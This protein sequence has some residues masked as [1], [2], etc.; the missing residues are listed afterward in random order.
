MILYVLSTLSSSQLPSP[1]L[2][3]S[4]QLTSFSL[5]LSWLDTAA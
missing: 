4:L 3:H 1:N 2:L 5:G